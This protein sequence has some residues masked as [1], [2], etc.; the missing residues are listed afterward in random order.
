MRF[1]F[2]RCQTGSGGNGLSESFVGDKAPTSQLA[3][4]VVLVVKE[5]MGANP[6]ISL[7]RSS[8]VGLH[9]GARRERVKSSSL[10][11]NLRGWPSSL[12][13]FERR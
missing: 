8:R 9:R 7:V 5:T 3:G 4:P 13:A 11:A 12:R 1:A 6:W 2:P 10:G